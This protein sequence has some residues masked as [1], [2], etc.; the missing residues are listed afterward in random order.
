MK[1]NS[2]FPEVHLK[3]VIYFPFFNF[4]AAARSSKYPDIPN[5]EMSYL[6]ILRRFDKVI[7]IELR[8]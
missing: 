5:Q 4:V 1:N 3:T 2:N 6:T 8:L 7:L